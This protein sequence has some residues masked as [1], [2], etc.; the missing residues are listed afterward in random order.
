MLKEDLIIYKCRK[1]NAFV[2]TPVQHR[3][4]VESLK[5][6]NAFIFSSLNWEF[7]LKGLV[8]IKNHKKNSSLCILLALAIK[9]AFLTLKENRISAVAFK[10]SGA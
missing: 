9:I 7:H 5:Y 4:K 6:V 1:R 10:N 3:Y 8:I 2:T